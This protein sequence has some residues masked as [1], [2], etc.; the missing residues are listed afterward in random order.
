[1]TSKIVPSTAPQ[2]GVPTYDL[3]DQGSAALMNVTLTEILAFLADENEMFVRN[4]MDPREFYKSSHPT[5][6]TCWC[7]YLAVAYVHTVDPRNGTE[8]GMPRCL[9][10]L[11]GPNDEAFPGA[12]DKLTGGRN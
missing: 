2:T 10:C 7:G 12:Q 1:M 8:Y 6:G 3:Y 5:D 11:L 4:E 9:D